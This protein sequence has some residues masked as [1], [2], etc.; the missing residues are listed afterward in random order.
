MWN[1][2]RVLT[3]AIEPLQR[4]IKIGLLDSGVK[5]THPYLQNK[6]V[7]KRNLTLHNST[8]EAGHGTQVSG[9]INILN[10]NITL[11]S[12]KLYNHFHEIN[13]LNI[14]KG[15]YKAAGDGVNLLNISLGTYQ[16]NSTLRGNLIIESYK[17]AIQYAKSKGMLIVASS[18]ND[19]IDTRN[20]SMIHLPSDLDSVIS[21]GS[22]TRFNKVAPY[23]N[24][25]RNVD[26]Y[27]P[28]G[29]L[30]NE[31]GEKD[32]S[33]LIITYSSGHS[34]PLQGYNYI[35][36]IP[37]HLTLSYGTSLA[38]PQVLIALCILMDRF[39][40]KSFEFYKFKL[41]ENA[42]TLSNNSYE[43]RII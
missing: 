28:T 2:R 42:Y 35:S 15:I 6:I 19:G 25:G 40:N 31:L 33:Q 26:V 9:V 37:N 27:A 23:S 18:G 24:F 11:Y 20:I 1:Y 38:V 36:N 7:N 10:D 13:N 5:T 29:D 17:K 4:N 22:S 16:D 21:V 30:Y 12:Y 34:S 41:L 3:N 32:I 14:I 43:L 8:D 39:P